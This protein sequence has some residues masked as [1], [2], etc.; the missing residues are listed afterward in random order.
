[1]IKRKDLTTGDVSR[2]AGVAAR[3]ASKW[4][5][6][7]EIAGYRIPFTQDRRVHAASLAAFLRRHGMGHRVPLIGGEFG[8]VLFVGFEPSAHAALA[9]GLDRAAFAATAFEAG[10]QVASAAPAVVVLD[11]A[12]GRIEAS[13]LAASVRATGAKVVVVGG[14][15][16]RG[17]EAFD[18]IAPALADVPAAVRGLMS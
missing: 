10:V 6:A 11:P 3:T 18:A 2:I 5:D 16:G 15:G 13:S 7:G 1:M 4:I 8:A 14:F 9:D 12:M 17:D